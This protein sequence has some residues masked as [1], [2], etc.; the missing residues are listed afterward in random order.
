MMLA[1]GAIHRRASAVPSADKSDS[2]TQIQPDRHIQLM[3]ERGRIGWQQGIGYGRRN[4]AETAMLRY[5]HLIGPKLRSRSLSAR[6]GEAAIAVAV[7][8]T[9]IP[10]E[11]PVSVRVAYMP[12]GKGQLSL[13]PV[14]TPTSFR[15]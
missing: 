14:H 3:A 12:L 8:N 2:D 1:C 5:K 4:Q 6:R 15:T 10:T 9:M 11:K 13:A 7:L